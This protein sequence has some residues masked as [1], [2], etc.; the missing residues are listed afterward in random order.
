MVVGE[1]GGNDFLCLWRFQ[2]SLQTSDN[3]VLTNGIPGMLA[4]NILPHI[5]CYEVKELQVKALW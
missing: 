1:K 2:L 3:P 4:P 5:L